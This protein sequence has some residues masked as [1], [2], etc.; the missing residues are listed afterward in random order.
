MSFEMHLKHG[1][2]QAFM[3]TAW[4]PELEPPE[5]PNEIIGITAYNGLIG[6]LCTVERAER[7]IAAARAAGTFDSMEQGTRRVLVR[8]VELPGIS[9]SADAQAEDDPARD[10][11]NTGTL[12]AMIACL[13]EAGVDKVPLC[14]LKRGFIAVPSEQT[15][16]SAGIEA[17]ID[18]LRNI[19]C[20]VIRD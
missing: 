16:H 15:E 14:D 1:E 17:A 18:A 4:S 20:I 2:Y 3:I 7:V 19:G 6:V 12:L 8:E 5:D 9:E 10:I 13:A 11:G